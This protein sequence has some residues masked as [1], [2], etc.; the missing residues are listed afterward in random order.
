MPRARRP[1]PTR[2]RGVYPWC[3]MSASNPAAKPTKGPMPRIHSVQITGFLPVYRIAARSR[4]PLAGASRP[5]GEP[6][7]RPEMGIMRIDLRKVL[8]IAVGALALSFLVLAP[9]AASAGFL[10]DLFGSHRQDSP[11]AAMFDANPV[12]PPAPAIDQPHQ[13]AIA[14]VGYGSVC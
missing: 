9:V 7:L 5:T 3:A 2:G 13:P 4:E 10:D 1:E 11:D 8:P 12:A 6:A 14:S